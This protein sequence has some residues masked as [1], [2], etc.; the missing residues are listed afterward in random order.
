M[1][2]CL[3]LVLAICTALCVSAENAVYQDINYRINPENMTAEVT[4]NPQAS[5]ELYIPSEIHVGQ[6]KYRIQGV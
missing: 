4:L 3:S 2:C 1:K 6:Q 5:G